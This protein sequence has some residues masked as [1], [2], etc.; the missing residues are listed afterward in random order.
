MS[1]DDL[2]N[3][4][5]QTLKKMMEDAGLQFVSKEQAIEELS[6][7]QAPADPDAAAG[8]AAA[9]ASVDRLLGN[10]APAASDQAPVG[11]SFDRSKPYGEIFGDVPDAPGAR[12]LQDGHYFNTAGG[13]VGKA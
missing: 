11:P 7:R 13:I 2:K 5:W 12:F 9:D 10:P 3:L 8:A 6:K 1:I 4:H